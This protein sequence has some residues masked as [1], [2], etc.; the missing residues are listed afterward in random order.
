MYDN[1]SCGFDKD[2]AYCYRA[3]FHR[4]VE[5]EESSVDAPDQ[6][7]IIALKGQLRFKFNLG[8]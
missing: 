8:P 4:F 2:R 6:G 3:P 7:N 5:D 1:S